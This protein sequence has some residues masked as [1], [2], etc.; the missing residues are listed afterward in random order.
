MYQVLLQEFLLQEIFLKN[1]SEVKQEGWFTRSKPA[2]D[3]I[4]E[5][6]KIPTPRSTRITASRITITTRAVHQPMRLIPTTPTER[7]EPQPTHVVPRTIRPT[8]RSVTYTSREI[9]VFTPDDEDQS[10]Q[11]VLPPSTT[12]LTLSA[13]VEIIVSLY[14]QPTQPFFQLN[15]IS[16]KQKT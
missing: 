8:A 12:A 6:R 15:D 2:Q 4:T 9:K 14:H 10:S 13:P 11:E 1:R 16:R 3:V 5:E 7:N